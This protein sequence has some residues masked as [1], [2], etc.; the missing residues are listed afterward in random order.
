[1]S[2]LSV[3]LFNQAEYLQEKVSLFFSIVC[4]NTKLGI[5]EKF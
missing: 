5:R 2:R 3:F 1:M 4:E